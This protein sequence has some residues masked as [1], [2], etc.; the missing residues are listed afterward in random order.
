MSFFFK[1]LVQQISRKSILNDAVLR[2]FQCE[3]LVMRMQASRLDGL[4]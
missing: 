3:T 1:L 4:I 2:L